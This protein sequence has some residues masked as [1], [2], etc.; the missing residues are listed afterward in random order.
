MVVLETVRA[1]APA[2]RGVDFGGV[3]DVSSSRTHNI[4]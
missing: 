3:V 1:C 4:R 2:V